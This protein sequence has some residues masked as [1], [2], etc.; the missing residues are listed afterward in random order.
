MIFSVGQAATGTENGNNRKYAGFFG[1]ALSIV[2]AAGTLTPTDGCYI[3]A[4]STQANWVFTCALNNVR[5]AGVDTG[6]ASTSQRARFAIELSTS[7]ANCL[8]FDVNSWVT[9]GAVTAQIPSANL[10]P[11]LRVTVMT[12]LQPTAIPSLG[13]GE[14]EVWHQKKSY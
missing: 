2:G 10:L 11:M 13:F 7:R 5:N 1:G 9:C 3:V 6:V 12:A 8:K 4:S 14:I